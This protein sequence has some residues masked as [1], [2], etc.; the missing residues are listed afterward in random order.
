[1]L[2]QAALRKRLDE[3]ETVRPIMLSDWQASPYILA[4][5]FPGYEGAV[6]MRLLAE[7]GVIVGT[8]SA[9]GHDRQRASHVVRAM[10]Y[11]T[12]TS[13]GMLRVSFSHSNGD[14]D[15]EL[16]VEALRKSL[17]YY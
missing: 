12:Q 9:C 1:M 4:F 8:G 7:E 6:L 10:G 17:E 11:D 14:A 2:P 16:L 15:V 5:S 3:M 13:R